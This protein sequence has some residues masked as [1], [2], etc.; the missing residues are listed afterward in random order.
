MVQ[1]LV[2]ESQSPRVPEHN[3]VTTDSRIHLQRT[4]PPFAQGASAPPL[5]TEVHRT[6]IFN[7]AAIFQGE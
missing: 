1:L 6:N 4:T 2:G 3:T 5:L 7:P